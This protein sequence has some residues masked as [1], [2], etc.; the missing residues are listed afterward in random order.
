MFCNHSTSG[1]NQTVH[2]AT[3]EGNNTDG[4]PLW[5]SRTCPTTGKTQRQN[6]TEQAGTFF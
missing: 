3:E 5:C 6:F 4:Y 2:T 1:E